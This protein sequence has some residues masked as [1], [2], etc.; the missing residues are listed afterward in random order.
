MCKLQ[1]SI[2][3]G[4]EALV[5]RCIV[6]K[7]PADELLVECALDL[8]G[9]LVLDVVDDRVQVARVPVIRSLIRTVQIA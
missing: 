6:G 9:D 3:S 5:S 4:N 8:A 1:T 7:S 2:I